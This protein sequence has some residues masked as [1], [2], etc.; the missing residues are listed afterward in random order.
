MERHGGDLESHARRDEDDAED[1][2]DAGMAVLHGS[3]DAGIADRAGEAVGQRRAVEQHARRQRAEDEIFQPGFRRLRVVAVE[4]GD[5]IERQRLQFEADIEADE[6]IGRDH[7]HHADRRE[8]DQDRELE[9]HRAVATQGIRREQDRGGGTE[10][11]QHLEEAGEAVDDEA[12]VEG[13]HLALARQHQHESQREQ[14]QRPAFEQAR[15]AFAPDRADEHH[16][17]GAQ[18]EDDFRKRRAESG[19]SHPAR[20]Y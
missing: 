12:I 13:R 2:A 17:D 20:P 6:V 14:G 8:H 9:A 4:G 19:Q 1:Q 3:R 16:R 5:D 7:H 11:R 15:R 18:G 10:Q